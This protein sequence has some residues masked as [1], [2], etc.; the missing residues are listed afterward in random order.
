M[1]NKVIA[2][3]GP[4]GSGKSSTSKAV[5]KLLGYKFLDT[6]AMY[7][8]ATLYCMAQEVPLEDP[9]SVHCAIMQLANETAEGMGIDISLDPEEFYMR[10]GGLDVTQ[11][12]RTPEVTENIHY[13]SGNLDARPLIVQM[14]QDIVAEFEKSGI[15]LEGRDVTDVIAPHA[16]VRILLTASNEVRARRRSVDTGLDQ[17]EVLNSINKR[18]ALDSE[19]NDFTAET[20]GPQ[21][22]GVI[23]LDN[24]SLTLEQT[25]QKVAALMGEGR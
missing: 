4:A 18:D 15:V 24:S 11:D 16:R 12:I 6:G 17:A 7:R 20:L 1:T 14:Q 19:V 22:S 9:I 25:V 5:A 13:I 23:L 2:I 10:L 3:D 21:N 8:A